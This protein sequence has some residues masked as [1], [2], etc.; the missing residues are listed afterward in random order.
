MSS[1]ALVAGLADGL[2]DGLER[3]L[4]AA[5]VGRE[6]AL[7]ADRG[8]EAAA[9]EHALERVEDF[10]AG[11]QRFG[12]RVEADRQHHE[13]LHV[14][15]VV[16]MRAAVDDV[17]HR[18]RQRRPRDHRRDAATAAS[19]GSSPRACALAI[20]TP[21]NALAP[22]RPLLS[23]PSRSISRR[24][25]PAWSAASKPASALAIVVLTFSTALR[26]PLP[27]V[28]GLVAVAQ[29]DRFLAAGRGARRHHRAA[30]AAIAQRDFGF[31]RGIAAGVE[32]FAGVDL[33]DRGHRWT[34]VP[35]RREWV[36]P[37]V[38]GSRCTQAGIRGS[39]C[40]WSLRRAPSAFPATRASCPA[41]TRSG[42]RTAPCP[43]PD[44]F[45]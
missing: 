35:L 8:A 40:A 26:T 5:Q 13:L 43:D 3:F 22:R 32:D 1:P 18:H 28:A 37:P 14:D 27:Q 20:D 41:A 21:S 31:E 2:E 34:V 33:G 29:L 15:I 4:V 16:G 25:R 36:W 38:V 45:P 10:G 44:G 39:R 42:R 17:H 12:E 19:C 11:A 6:T 9:L 23:V 7:V 30:E 24:S